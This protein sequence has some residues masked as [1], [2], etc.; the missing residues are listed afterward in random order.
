[1]KKRKLFHVEDT[2]FF[3]KKRKITEVIV[4]EPNKKP[5]IPRLLIVLRILIARYRGHIDRCIYARKVFE[6]YS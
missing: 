4:N 2:D 5:H 3:T 6:F 1:M